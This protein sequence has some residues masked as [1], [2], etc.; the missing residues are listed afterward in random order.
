MVRS[1]SHSRVISE[2]VFDVDEMYGIAFKIVVS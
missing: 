1:K 2:I